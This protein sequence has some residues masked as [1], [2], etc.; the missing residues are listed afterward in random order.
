MNSLSFVWL[1]VAMPGPL[2]LL[3]IFVVALLLFGAKRLPDIA[4]GLG[5]GIR[6]FKK[7]ISEAG[8]S[9]EIGEDKH[10]STPKG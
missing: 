5:E 10:K 4:R 3:M 7:S 1:F 6:E 2:E 9:L 8:K